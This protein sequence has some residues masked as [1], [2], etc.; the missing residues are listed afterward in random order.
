M[1]VCVCVCVQEIVERQQYIESVI[2]TS[3]F[4]HF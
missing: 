3:F 1:C 2:V 4:V